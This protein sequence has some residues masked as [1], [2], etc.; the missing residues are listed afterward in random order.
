[1]LLGFAFVA[2]TLY[3]PQGIAGLIDRLFP[4]RT[5]APGPDPD[6]RRITPAEGAQS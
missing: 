3:A 1:V 5:R 4:W 2:V 6:A